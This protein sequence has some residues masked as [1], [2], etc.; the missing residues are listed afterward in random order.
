MRNPE[1]IKQMEKAWKTEKAAWTKDSTKASDPT[2][3]PYDDRKV[4]GN[5]EDFLKKD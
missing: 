3:R 2:V 1:Q 4:I 5:A